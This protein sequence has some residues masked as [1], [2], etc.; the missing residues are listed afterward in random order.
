VK[1]INSHKTTINTY[2]LVI[3]VIISLGLVG[4]GTYHY[5]A[6]YYQDKSLKEF[7]TSQQNLICQARIQKGHTGDIK[8]DYFVNETSSKQ[9]D[10]AKYINYKNLPSD[11]QYFWV[12]K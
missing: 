11:T 8:T 2:L 6:K 5:T 12:G 1:A 7:T 3:I 9:D 10:C 4:F